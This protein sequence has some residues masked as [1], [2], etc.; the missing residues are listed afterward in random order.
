[1][2]RW[3]GYVIAHRR[4]VIAAWLVLFVLGGFAAANL[5]G[6]LSNRFS[7]PGS[8]SENGLNLL[9]DHMGDRSDG[10]FTLVAGGVDNAAD[11]QAV[12]A[13]AQRGAQAIVGGKAGPL[14]DAGKG[15]VYAQIATPLE[16]QDA[17]KATPEVRGAIGKVPGV[18]TFL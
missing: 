7:V 4:R 15:V 3:T 9:K 10:S 16:N 8:E 14:L 1:M 18:E 6:L 2:S 13:A 11:R 12:Q 5:G 17:A